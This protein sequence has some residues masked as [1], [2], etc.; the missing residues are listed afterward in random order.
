MGEWVSE[1]VSVC[2]C[3]CV[4]VATLAA[5]NLAFEAFA[6]AALASASM[7]TCCFVGF[8]GFSSTFSGSGSKAW[9]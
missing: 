6:F 3:A 9:G 1:C 7:D 5:P 8:F 2:V 4:R